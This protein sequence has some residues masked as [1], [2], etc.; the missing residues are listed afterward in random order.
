M[1]RF[2]CK[3]C[4][5]KFSV[6]ESR[7]G[8]KGKCPKCRNIIVVPEIQ[9]ASSLTEQSDSGVP[10]VSSKSS[11]DNITLLKAIEKDKIQDEP[12]GLSS[13][14]EQATK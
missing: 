3:S 11:A 4:G 6:P 13:V 9:A 14:P 5:Q 1:I 8:K 2:N 10:D 7:A 12:I